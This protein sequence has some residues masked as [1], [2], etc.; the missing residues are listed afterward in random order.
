MSAWLLIGLALSL[1]FTGKPTY[2]ACAFQPPE[3]APP[4]A[5]TIARSYRTVTLTIPSTGHVE[6]H[7]T[8]LSA[9]SISFDSPLPYGNVNYAINR[10]DLSIVQT[11]TGPSVATSIVQGQCRLQPAAK[12]VL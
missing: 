5:L 2:L 9:S 11:S 4:I 3:K 12:P 1:P 10:T 8:S 6:Q 7:R